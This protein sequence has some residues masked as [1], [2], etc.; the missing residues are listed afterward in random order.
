MALYHTTFVLEV[1]SD[2]PVEFLDLQSLAYE[3]TEGDCSG[4]FLLK[5]KGEVTPDEMRELLTLQG[6][7]PEF[8]PELEE[9]VSKEE[10][11]LEPW[12]HGRNCMC[13]AH[14]MSERM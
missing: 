9:E 14:L 2:R 11:Y 3:I 5:G 8:F 6:S 7:D 12:Q 10:A 13:S 4:E 1:L